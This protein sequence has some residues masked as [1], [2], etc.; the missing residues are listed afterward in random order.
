MYTQ[1]RKIIFRIG[2]ETSHILVIKLLKC[3]RCIPFAKSI[4]RLAFSVRDKSLEREV[5]GIRFK[6]PV[7]L[8]AGFD[9]N[10]EVVGELDCLGFGFVEIGSVTPLPQSGN[11]RPR[12]F[13][14][15][16]D[17]ALINRMGVNNAG[18]KAVIKSLH[19]CRRRKQIVVGGNLSKNTTTFN[20]HAP[21]DYERCFALLYNEVDYFVVNVSCPNV[22]DLTQ[23]QDRDILTQIIDRLVNVRHYRDDYKPILLKIS[24]DL[25]TAQL[26]DIIDLV[27]EKGIDGIVAVNTTVT[28]EALQ[29][30][31]E[32]V[33]A[34]GKG[35]LSGAPLA[36]KAIER[37]RYIHTKTE[38]QVPIIGV[39]GIMTPDDA[40]NMLAAGASLIQ[41]YTGFIYNGPIFVKKILKRLKQEDSWTQPLLP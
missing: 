33:E 8:A 12:I 9:K 32:K 13:R 11:P 39:G 41:V 31:A 7:G 34:L 18:A 2:P 3:L 25:N 38:G 16:A 29:T 17:K 35:G 36:A 37:V 15:P 19:R 28:R 5:L 27:R 6:N 14:L 30:P 21:A 4:L 22:S 40:V 1:L 23:L 24:P 26:D 10:A 20:V